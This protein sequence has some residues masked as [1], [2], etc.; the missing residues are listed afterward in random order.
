M[1]EVRNLH[2]TFNGNPVLKGVDFNIQKGEVVAILGPFGSGKTTFLR[3]LNLLERPELG[4]LRFC[5]GSLAL[6]FS[7]KMLPGCCGACA[8]VAATARSP[9]GVCLPCR[10]WPPCC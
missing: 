7:H 1:L 6:D 5:D 2:K 9:A 8:T 4:T 10:C 3:C